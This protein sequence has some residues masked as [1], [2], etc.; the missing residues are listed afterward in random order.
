MPRVRDKEVVGN[1]WT[2]TGAL[3]GSALA[4]LPGVD[5]LRPPPPALSILTPDAITITIE[6]ADVLAD[7]IDRSLRIGG[8]VA[9]PTR[10]VDVYQRRWQKPRSATTISRMATAAVSRHTVFD[11]LGPVTSNVTGPL[12]RE[13]SSGALST[14]YATP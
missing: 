7:H 10:A 3:T 2:A 9:C 11:A 4:C 12:V 6:V 14:E 13:L 1:P 8:A 5:D